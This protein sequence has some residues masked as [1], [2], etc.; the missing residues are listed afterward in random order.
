M[1]SDK[2][3]IA[4]LT[5]L[6][7]QYGVSDV[8]ICPGSRNT[9]LTHN[10]VASPRLRCHAVTDERSAAFYAL[11]MAAA[12][13]RPV[14]VCVTSGSAVVNTSPAMAEAYYRHLP[15]IV[16]AAD[17][18]E[19]WTG[20]LDGQTLP[21]ARA[22]GAMTRCCVSLPE[23]ATDIERWHCRRLIC[24][25][26]A[27]STSAQGGP[28]MVNIPISEPL[29]EYSRPA[30]PDTKPIYRVSP[31]DEEACRQ[32]LSFVSEATCPVIVLG[33][34]ER[35][36]VRAETVAALQRKYIVAY[37]PLATD[38][39]VRSL[40]TALPREARPSVL[41]LGGVL[42]SKQWRQ[43]LRRESGGS[44]VVCHAA[45]DFAD[46]LMNAGLIAEATRYDDI[47]RA[48]AEDRHDPT[49]G[50]DY[51]AWHTAWEQAGEG[52]EEEESLPYGA[53][54][55]VRYLEEQTD[56]LELTRAVHYANSTAVRLGERY[57]HH[58]IYC[59]RGV[60]GIE[61]SLSAA[62]GHSLVT[63]DTVVCITGDL[64]FFY[65]QN[66]LWNASLR[67]NLRVML[68]GDGGGAI[69][70]R[71]AGMR[72]SDRD[73]PYVAAT[74]QTSARGICEAYDLGY[75][76]AEDEEGMRWGIVRLL[77][78]ESHRPIVLEVKL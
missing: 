30:L 74:H 2:E 66:A 28:V 37:S 67:G 34:M 65:D 46:P 49:A 17:R 31:T 40:P 53:A 57:A 59:N 41:Y 38:L 69:F 58:Y 43:W 19:A 25:A 62:A 11:G 1:Y 3:N 75:L 42:V 71:V 29:F 26:L 22:A 10:L 78:M 50:K 16:L 35:G 27:Q 70:D 7:P 8:V 23:P 14:A 68:L 6:L 4:L 63:D 36:E 64:S 5:A 12:Q 52:A 60:N 45:D 72:L 73:R 76:H 18:P 20:Q 77:T 61:G 33:K 39:P 51:A 21:Q 44:M 24:Q 13:R 9:P 55:A 32:A 48:L 47:L 54:L 15:L 56:D